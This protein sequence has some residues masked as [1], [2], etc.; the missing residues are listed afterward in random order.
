MYQKVTLGGTF[1]RFHK[2][3]KTILG[4]TFAVGTHVYLGITTDKYVKE[5]ITKKHKLSSKIQSH[6]DRLA[7]VEDYLRSKHLLHR[8]TII[9][10]SDRF[11]TTLT[12]ENLE[13]IVVSPETE[14]VAT[15]IN[16]L[17]AQKNWPALEVATVSWI[18]AEDKQP[19]S[20]FR[21]R[22]GEID[23]NGKLYSLPK[24]WG[25]RKLPESLRDD[26]RKPFGDL[27]SETSHDFEIAVKDF[28]IHYL[29][30][31]KCTIFDPS[32]EAFVISIGD[33]VTHAL[34]VI[35]IV[36][37]ISIVDLKIK[38]IPVYKNVNEL[39]IR[40]IKVV[41]RVKNTAGTLSF[42][43]FSVLNSLIKS[44]AERAVLQIDGEEDLLT[45]LAIFRAPLGSLIVYG[46]P[47]VSDTDSQGIV[48]VEVTEEKK[49]EARE[50]LNKFHK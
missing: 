23:R 25:M 7:A 11:G 39:G 47:K 22:K 29:E 34:A 32:C 9:E 50:L 31:G 43:T 6:K 27:I 42:A 41:K 26:L 13:A 20:S 30:G 4:K 46:Q 28:V 37:N 38:R 18:L 12:D 44:E 19:I 8:T 21:I 17:R 45:L 2:G 48:V 3:H 15:E 36:P 1:D 14:L 49:N 40:D 5:S 24:K 33:A 10:L 16:L 35:G